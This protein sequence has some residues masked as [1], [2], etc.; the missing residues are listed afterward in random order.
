MSD[1][2]MLT[3][4]NSTNMTKDNSPNTPIHEDVSRNIDVP[5][6]D[7][8]IFE[9]PWPWLERFGILVFRSW[10]PR[11][12]FWIATCT[13]VPL[14]LSCS[15]RNRKV[16]LDLKETETG[17]RIRR[18]FGLPEIWMDESEDELARN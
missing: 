15:P 1:Q 9:A 10:H 14:V 13:F 6:I 3:E 2:P 17:N 5:T 11:C 4:A 8:P 12:S 18:F 16:W 7:D